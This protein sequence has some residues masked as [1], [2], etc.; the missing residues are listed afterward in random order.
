MKIEIEHFQLVEK[1]TN[2]LVFCYHYEDKIKCNTHSIS[3]DRKAQR[4]YALFRVGT[5][6]VKYKNR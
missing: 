2:I 4:T 5:W 6:S 1:P 3:F